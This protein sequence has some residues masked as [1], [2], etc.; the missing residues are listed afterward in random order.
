MR[1]SK[2]MTHFNSYIKIDVCKETI[3]PLI[4]ARD[5]S[6]SWIWVLAASLSR[7]TGGEK[8]IM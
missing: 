3:A 5:V 8:Q 1:T 6:A 2:Q 4:I 7:T